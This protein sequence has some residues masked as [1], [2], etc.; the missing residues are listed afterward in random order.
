MHNMYIHGAA[1]F[2]FLCQK[3]IAGNRTPAVVV[4]PTQLRVRLSFAPSLAAFEAKRRIENV[5]FNMY[6]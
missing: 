3:H 1:V 6:L 4:K 5:F 2:D